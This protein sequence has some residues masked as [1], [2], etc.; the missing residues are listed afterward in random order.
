VQRAFPDWGWHPSLNIGQSTHLPVQ[1]F[2]EPGTWKL[3]NFVTCQ[4][5]CSQHVKQ[6]RL[7]PPSCSWLSSHG[8][9]SKSAASYWLVWR[10]LSPIQALVTHRRAGKYY[11]MDWQNTSV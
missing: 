2:F 6:S 1:H 10:I 7:Y 3:G 9:N 4:V 8:L 11:S 5:H